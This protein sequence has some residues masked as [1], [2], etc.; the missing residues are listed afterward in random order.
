LV[1]GR[2]PWLRASTEKVDIQILDL[3]SKQV[4]TIP[5]SENLFSPR[6]SPDGRRLAAVSIDNKKL[7]LFDFKTKKW[8]DWIEEPGAVSYPTWSDDGRYVYYGNMSSKGPAYRRVRIGQTHSEPLIDLKDLRL[9]I[10]SLLGP[11]SGIGPDR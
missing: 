9:A 4:S 1:F 11:W 10:P 2:V 6:W 8:I 5:G 7:L 3:D